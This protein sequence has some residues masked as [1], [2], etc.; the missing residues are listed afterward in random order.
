MLLPGIC[1]CAHAIAQGDDQVFLFSFFDSNGEN[2][3][4]MA[5]SEDGRAFNLL[6]NGQPLIT[7]PAWADS[8]TLM[9]DPSI[10]Y[11]DGAF[12]MVWTT[13]W[14]GRVFGCAS[15]TDLKTW[16]TQQVTPYSPSLPGTEQPDNVWA[17]E[18]FYDHIAGNYKIVWAS[19]IPSER[20]DGDGTA[21]G[22]YD[23]RLWAT[24]TT[25][26]ET[27][28]PAE[29]F[30][31]ANADVID[32]MSAYD[33]A[34]S[35][36]LMMTAA[37]GVIKMTTHAAVLTGPTG[38]S[39]Q[40]AAI[41]G[42]GTAINGGKRGE[43]PTLLKHG[44]EWLL[45][46]DSTWDGDWGMASST[47][48]A[49]WN[50][51]TPQFHVYY[52][53]GAEYGHPRHGTVSLVPRSALAAFPEVPSSPDAGVV[54]PRAHLMFDETSGTLAADATGNQWTGTLVN[55]PTFVPGKDGNAVSLDGSN[56]HVSLPTGVVSS[57]GDFTIS[58]WVKLNSINMWSRIFDFGRGTSVYM[59]LTPCSGS[60]VAR[61]AITTTGNSGEQG[62]NGTAALPADVWTHVA[63]TLAGNTG[64][65]YVNGVEVG[66]NSA[67]TLKPYSLGPT[68][69]NWIGRSQ[70]PDPYLNGVV[71]DFR[72]SSG[73]LSPYE[74]GSQAGL[75]PGPAPDAP[76]SLT[77]ASPSSNRINLAWTASAGATGYNIGRATTSGGPYVVIVSNTNATNYSDD[78]VSP[79]ATYYYVVSAVNSLGESTWSAEASA[80][81]DYL[82]LH[83][84]L[85]E[86]SGATAADSSGKDRNATL[87]SGPAFAPGR[88]DN[89]LVFAGSSSQYATLPA[90]LVSTLNDFTI[91]TWVKPTSLQNW[92]RVFDFGSGTATNMFLTAQSGATGKPRFAIKISDSAEQIIDAPDAL[93]TGVWTHLAVTLSGT[94][95]TLYVNGVAVGTNTAMGFKPSSMG[96]TTQNYLCKSQYA[97]PYLDGAL[98]DFRIYASALSASDV[99]I[100]AAGELAAPENLTATPGASQIALSWNSVAGATGYTV[101]RSSENGGPFTDLATEVAATTYLDSGLADGATWH[102]TVT[103]HGLPGVGPASAPV[104]ATTYTAQENWR[105]AH[106]GTPAD[107]GA[108]AA[109][110]D[111]DGDGWTNAQEFISGTDPNNHASLLKVT[112][113]HTSENDIVLNFPTV[114]GKSYRLERSD[115]LLEGSWT[116]VEDNIPG[117]GTE[118]Q[119]SDPDGALHAKRFYRIVVAP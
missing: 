45:Y 20:S 109:D 21:V 47:N 119:V 36:W 89:A 7:P 101:R 11:R 115:S 95:G 27:F 74:V 18:I 14:S 53:N 64:I 118:I 12:R 108:A 37:S 80:R 3:V 2:G 50:D 57:L 84:K 25:D 28:T 44:S 105:L 19:T 104:F 8:Q 91:S 35:R 83:L 63:V 117:T 106:F 72:I 102:Y 34:N 40:S 1:A 71:D 4:Y 68:T 33:E 30:Y 26:F 55:G 6:N 97:D 61:F 38:W 41:V 49:T 29:L 81:P 100:L 24:T 116:T 88:I 31:D 75:P 79:A 114:S 59:Y 65:L 113:M 107:S 32:G 62:I 16:S 93:A 52:P 110:A 22:N 73:V 69:L 77:A 112:Q 96:N 60:G 86:T 51:L 103:A 90:G 48:L 13:N 78:N 98:D 9:R 76:A 10:I 99:G 82:H 39:A 54:S 46:W 17:P 85:D 111:P 67:M 70:F 56:D 92:A 94:T 43:G 58:A 15:S 42:P 87:V 5:W 66:R 23:N